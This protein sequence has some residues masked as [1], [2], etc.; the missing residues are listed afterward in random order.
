MDHHQLKARLGLRTP[1]QPFL[2]QRSNG[3]WHHRGPRLF[4]EGRPAFEAKLRQIQKGRPTGLGLG[5]AGR[6]LQGPRCLVNSSYL[7]GSCTAPCKAPNTCVPTNPTV[8]T[9]CASDMRTWQ[10]DGHRPKPL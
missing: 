2:G 1:C 3:G 8:P 10:G 9:L 7:S 4:Q 5:P 6:R